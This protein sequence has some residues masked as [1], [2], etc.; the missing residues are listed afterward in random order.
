MS[1]FIEAH[2][3][4][5]G[6]EPICRVLA[7]APSSYYAAR[8]RPPSARAVRD[9][10]LVTAIRRVHLA[11]YGVYGSR[12]VWHALRREGTAVGRDRVARLMRAEGLVGVTRAKGARTTVRAQDVAGPPDLVGRDFRSLAPDRLWVADLTYVRWSGGFCYTA[13]VSDAYARR[14]VGW[15]VTASA[16]AEHVLDALELAAWSRRGRSLEGLVHHSDHGSQYLALRYTERVA[17]L[18]ARVSAGSVGDSYDN[19]LAET[20][21]GLYKAE[22]IHRRG[23]W[24]SVA[25]VEVA[26]AEWVR[27]WNERRLHSAL[28]YVPPAEYEAAY[29]QRQAAAA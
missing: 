27:W 17:E 10:E 28:G 16:T 15:R 9:A 23:P 18:G 1:A 3:G 13:F 22:L 26:T 21:F 29:W 12:K 8:G 4:R 2:R 25:Q 6:V 24:H 20:V 11:D 14:I 5:F 19:A 7:V